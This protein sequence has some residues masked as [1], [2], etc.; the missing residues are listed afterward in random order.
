MQARNKPRYRLFLLL[1]IAIAAFLTEGTGVAT[2]V[3]ITGGE[4]EVTLTA[5]DLLRTA[6]LNVT[7]LGT[8]TLN[9]DTTPPVVTFPITGGETQTPGGGALIEHE[10][11]GIEL[12]NVRNRVFLEDFVI[13]TGADTLSGDVTLFNPGPGV[14]LDVT[15]FNLTAC[16]SETCLELTEDGSIALARSF[17]RGNLTDTLFGTADVN[18]QTAAAVPEPSTLLLVGAGILGLL[19]FRKMR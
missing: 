2:A 10:G 16:D 15:L 14:L 7:P 9:A 19:G 1:L 3:P 11:S 18:F 6:E 8:A 12:S 17:G 5:T 13:D 4:T